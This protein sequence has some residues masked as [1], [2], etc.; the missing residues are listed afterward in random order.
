MAR[1][2][3]IAVSLLLLALAAPASYA[4]APDDA[5]DTRAAALGDGAVDAGSEEPGG[6]ALGDPHGAH[7]TW[8]TARPAVQADQ[9]PR[10]GPAATGAIFVP[11]MTDSVLE[12]PYVVRDADGDDVATTPMGRKTFVVPGR[13]TVLVGSGADEAK[14]KFDTV[15]VEGRITWVPVEWAGL[16]VNVVDARGN[17]FRGSY[18]LVRMPERDYV[19]IGLGANIAQGER[20]NTWVLYPGKYMILVAG[21]SYQARRN[22]ATLRL[23]PGELVQYTLVLDSDTGELLGAGEIASFRPQQR[24]SGWTGSLV[25]GGTFELNQSERVVGRTDGTLL[26]IAGFAE[27]L[28][29]YKNDVHLFYGRLN[30]EVGGDLR[31]PDQPFV[32]NVDELTLDLLYVYR[33]APWFGPYVR[34]SI[35]TQVLPGIQ[36]FEQP[37]D[38][39]KLS[40][41]GV[42]LGVETSRSSF[43]LAE[44]F[45]PIEPRYGTGV[46]FD[47]NF[48]GVLNI[49]TRVGV[50]GRHVYTR[51]LFIL[52]DDASTAE[53]EVRRVADVDQFGAEAALVA[54]LTLGRW[55]VLKLDTSVLFP[56]DDYDETFVDFRGA[57]TLRLTSFASLNY[58]VR[59]KDD[60]ALSVDTQLDHAV[61]LRLAYKL[62]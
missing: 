32:S 62:F 1:H 13:Y 61:L 53:Y 45:S 16:V 21:E 8:D 7:R 36:P 11:A 24:S 4:A 9:D 12:P 28:F 54:E 14:L 46:R 42:E 41:S 20:L 26:G 22:F 3:L 39:R 31:L 47:A 19:G 5:P 52:A 59:I 23:P 17:P 35:E 43:T 2:G 50:G 51:G 49:A 58:T 25:L 34:A 44:P 60:P 57:I 37:T 48:G 29:G 38:V 55:V 6:K 10:I 15:V 18:E 33:V 56:F 27:S 40:A 30:L